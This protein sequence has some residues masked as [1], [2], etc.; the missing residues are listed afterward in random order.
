MFKWLYIFYECALCRYW[1]GEVCNWQIAALRTSAP[2]WTTPVK[3]WSCWWSMA[4]TCECWLESSIPLSFYYLSRPRSLLECKMG[5]TPAVTSPLTFQCSI[6][7][8]LNIPI[9]CHLSS[10][11]YTGEASS[12]QPQFVLQKYHICTGCEWQ[13][14]GYR[15]GWCPPQ[16]R[17]PDLVVPLNATT[18]TQDDSLCSLLSHSWYLRLRRFHNEPMEA[19]RNQQVNSRSA[20]V[21]Q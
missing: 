13:G 18:V 6:S 19:A 8:N 5:Q 2:S 1:S 11:E 12:T 7:N 9:G 15:P 21:L 17:V 14:G 16:P 20:Y 10:E 4:W 3:W